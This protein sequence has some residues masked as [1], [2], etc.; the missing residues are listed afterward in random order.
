MK[1]VDIGD[2]A[3]GIRPDS[4]ADRID[5]LDR[6]QLQRMNVSDEAIDTQLRYIKDRSLGR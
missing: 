3:V 5:L 1:V 4:S 6:E 2:Q